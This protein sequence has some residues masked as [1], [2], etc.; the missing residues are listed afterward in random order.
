MCPEEADAQPL[1][2]D[3]ILDA[4]RHLRGQRVMLDED[5]ASLYNVET[6][7]LNQAVRRNSDR[8]PEDFMFQL[9]EEEWANLK[10]QIVISSA[11]GGR[12][13]PPLA[14]TQEGVAMLSSVLRGDRAI[15]VNIEIMRAFVRFRQYLANNAELSSKLR[16][17]EL[18]FEGKFARQ[19]QHTRMLFE[20]MRQL[21]SEIR[22][23]PSSV[24]PKR[25][26]GFHQDDEESP[27]S[28]ETSTK[29][30]ARGKSAK[31]K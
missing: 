17:L 3:A 16:E 5:L 28:R 27:K 6:R 23:P 21:R 24:V 12:R 29:G 2:P 26:I 19:D 4:I 31:N 7:A 1:A 20:A 14:F 25:R 9:T 18:R 15:Q 30:R 22:Q 11:H 13:T 8:F 10:S